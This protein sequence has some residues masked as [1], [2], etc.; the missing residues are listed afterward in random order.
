MEYSRIRKDIKAGYVQGGPYKCA[1]DLMSGLKEIGNCVAQSFRDEISQISG[2]HL[3]GF[4]HV[5]YS[6]WN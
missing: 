6:L 1:Q 5:L 2:L 4:V 3:G